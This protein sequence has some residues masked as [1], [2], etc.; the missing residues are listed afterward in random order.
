MTERSSYEKEVT[1]ALRVFTMI[2]GST[3][4]KDPDNRWGDKGHFPCPKCNVGSVHWYRSP[5]N[6][7]AR[8]C[9]STENCCS[10]IE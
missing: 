4:K 9:C 5:I 6:G 7:H 8:F 1:G 3:R 2:P 10:G